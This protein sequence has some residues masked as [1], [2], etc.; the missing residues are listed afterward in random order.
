MSTRIH[1]VTLTPLKRDARRMTV[2]LGVIS[3][4]VVVAGWYPEGEGDAIHTGADLSAYEE[5]RGRLKQRASR[6]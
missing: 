6:T 1:P 2:R 5:A 4:E 3:E